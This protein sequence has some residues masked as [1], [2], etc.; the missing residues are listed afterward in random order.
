MRYEEVEQWSKDRG[1]A[2]EDWK[3]KK[4][5]QLILL[6]SEQF[7]QL[8]GNIDDMITATPLTYEDYIGT[9]QGA[10]YGTDRDFHNPMA[11]YVFPRTKIPN[12]FFTGQNI[13]LHGMLG[14]SIS[15]LLSCGEI[16]GLHELIKEINEA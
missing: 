4:A 10:M 16:V 14:V 9:P 7:P 8:K 11:S 13:N 2:Y 5:K 6:A 15:S 3:E 1:P 12:L